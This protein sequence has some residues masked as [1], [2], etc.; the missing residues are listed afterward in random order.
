[1]EL[2]KEPKFFQGDTAS[3]RFPSQ[4]KD[5]VRRHWKLVYGV[6]IKDMDEF[7]SFGKF[8]IE[9]L[10][11][12]D[13]YDKE[14]SA[15]KSDYDKLAETAE[16][17][18]NQIDE[19]QNQSQEFTEV[20]EQVERLQQDIQDKEARISE[21]NEQLQQ[22]QES[23]QE[24]DSEELESLQSEIEEKDAEIERLSNDLEQA[25]RKGKNQFTFTINPHIRMAAELVSSKEQN[26]TGQNVTVQDV[27]L[28]T[29]WNQVKDGAG[30]HFPPVADSK[31]REIVRAAKKEMEQ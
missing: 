31:V 10:S 6:D 3:M 9:T 11:K 27:I 2:D 8:V 20:N 25:R 18:K 7:P 17:Q 23:K 30:D 28:H 5:F 19:L 16:N 22:L 13:A 29:F 1:M 4:D 15:L 12:L 14:Y 21:L 26:R 24:T